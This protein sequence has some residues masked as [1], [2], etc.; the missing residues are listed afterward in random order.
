MCPVKMTTATTLDVSCENDNS[1]DFRR[2]KNLSGVAPRSQC[3]MATQQMLRMPRGLWEDLEQTIINQDRA[4]LTMIARELGLPV[5]E[6]IQKCLGN[7]GTPQAVLLAADSLDGCPWFDRRGDGLWIPC[8]RQRIHS[9]RPCQFHERPGPASSL[10]IGHSLGKVF[11]VSY[12]G[13]IYWTTD[14]PDADVFREDGTVETELRF[15]FYEDEE[16]ER[17]ANCY[18]I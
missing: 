13:R 4:Y 5:K 16:G 3:S 7:S 8:H 10:L 1:D 12:Q 15:E 2:T 6:V 14:E 18:S 17:V 11:P 9:S